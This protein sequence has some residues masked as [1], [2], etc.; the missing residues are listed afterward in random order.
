MSEIKSAIEL[1]MERTKN[2]VM[3]EQEK[4]EFAQKDLEDKLRAVMRRFLEGMIEG[5]E[6]LNE[7]GSMKAEKTL[8]RGLLVDLLVQEFDTST[9]NERLFTL[10]E[11]VG[12]DA[13]GEFREE[14][15][16]LRG[17]FQEELRSREAGIRGNIID[18]LREMGISG[19]AIEPNVVE[20]EEWREATRE[21]GGR[22]KTRLQE[23]KER[24][25][26]VST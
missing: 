1:A 25:R 18:H 5:D 14:A 23:W 11:L 2:L 10:L 17:R 3:D 16:V 4:R 6:F 26:A 8:K 7:Y 12:G 9:G 20:W 19:S 21:I 24:I 22:F 13:G 15:F